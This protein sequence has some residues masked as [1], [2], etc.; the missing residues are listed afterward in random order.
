MEDFAFY[1]VTGGSGVS[2]GAVGLAGTTVVT[3][4][5]RGRRHP[6]VTLEALGR[7]VLDELTSA[8]S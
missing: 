4:R 1:P 7:R 6:A 5:G 8:P 3:L 2:V